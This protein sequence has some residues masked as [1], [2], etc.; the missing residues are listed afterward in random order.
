MLLNRLATNCMKRATFC[1]L[2]L[3]V[4]DSALA[5]EKLPSGG[6]IRDYASVNSWFIKRV[7]SD[8]AGRRTLYCEASWTR[9]ADLHVYARLDAATK[10]FALG[11]P[12]PRP[13]SRPNVTMRIWFDDQRASAI[14]GRWTFISWSGTTE[15]EDGYLVLTE[16]GDKGALAGRL[17]KARKVTFAY[18]FD[19]KTR[20]EAFPFKT[21]QQAMNKLADCASGR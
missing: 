19:G 11:I 5:V 7:S 10:A 3:V 21:A 16:T 6:F 12:A 2:V 15:G 17:A 20:T 4:S 9:E 13:T 8:E 18:P 1:C 14:E